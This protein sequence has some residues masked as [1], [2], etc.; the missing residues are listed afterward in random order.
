MRRQMK[1]PGTAGTAPGATIVGFGDATACNNRNPSRTASASGQ[2]GGN[3]VVLF[4][5]PY[6]GD[7]WRLEVTSH[8]GRTFGNWRKW[9]RN[10]EALLPTR[11]GVTIAL[12]RL[13]ELHAAIGDYLASAPPGAALRGV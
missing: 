3:S 9:Y 10:G 7:V 11:E 4:D 8:N 1:A 5:Q 12:E 6:R 13:P 2:E